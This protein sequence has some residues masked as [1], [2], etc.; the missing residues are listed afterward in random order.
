MIAAE[1]CAEVAKV[2]LHG[3]D[4]TRSLDGISWTRH[5]I[6]AAA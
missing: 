2:E 1:S 6:A 3:L 5:D 4:V